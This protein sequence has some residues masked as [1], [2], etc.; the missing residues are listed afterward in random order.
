VNVNLGSAD[1]KLRT[2]VVAPVLVVAGVLV[3]PA[4]V[5]AIVLYVLAAVMLGTSA[6]GSC[7][8]YMIFGLRSCP[9]K[10]ANTGAAKVTTS[11]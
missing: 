4:S 10:K 1:R 3:G 8:L 2:F 11:R 7:P 5:P 9:M 6:A